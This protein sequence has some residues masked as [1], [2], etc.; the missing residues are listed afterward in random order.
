LPI[1]FL[2]PLVFED[3]LHRLA[4]VGAVGGHLRLIFASL[5]TLPLIA[6]SPRLPTAILAVT[7]TVP[8][9]PLLPLLVV[10]RAGSTLCRTLAVA[11]SPS[12]P[13]PLG[14]VARTI[15]RTFPGL[16]LSTLVAASALILRLAAIGATLLIPLLRRPLPAVGRVSATLR[17]LTRLG[18]VALFARL[19]LPFLSRLARVARA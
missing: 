5:T 10:R 17:S 18:A 6:A 11:V 19:P 7:T 4:V 13:L 12:A 2:L 14:L 9:L 16:L 1:A 8:R 3:P 15:L